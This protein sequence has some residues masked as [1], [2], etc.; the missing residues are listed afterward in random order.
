[1]HAEANRPSNGGLLGIEVG[2]SGLYG[3]RVGGWLFGRVGGRV[4]VCGLPGSGSRRAVAREGDG[5][6][7]ANGA[8]AA[9]HKQAA[10]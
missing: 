6:R 7:F 10:T 9:A 1:M 4:G 3:G 5:A 8:L 2:Y